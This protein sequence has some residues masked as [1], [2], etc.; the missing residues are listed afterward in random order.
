V[1]GGHFLHHHKEEGKGKETVSPFRVAS[2]REKMSVSGS[3]SRISRIV[4]K[5]E[6]RENLMR[7]G[8][9]RHEF[10]GKK[11]RE[12]REA[13][14]HAQHR[15]KKERFSDHLSPEGGRKSRHFRRQR[16]EK[17]RGR[18]FSLDPVIKK[19]LILYALVKRKKRREGE[20]LPLQLKKKEKKGGRGASELSAYCFSLGA[21]CEERGKKD[22]LI[23]FE[24]RPLWSKKGKRG[25]RGGR[26]LAF[27]TLA[28]KIN[29]LLYFM[30]PKRRRGDKVKFSVISPRLRVKEQ[31]GRGQM[32]NIICRE[33]EKSRI[34]V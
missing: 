2:N 31:E 11:K 17:N 15:A 12:G 20:V 28:M 4:K 3:C 25:K 24:R 8:R 1:A 5:K 34:G 13:N 29:A 7:G 19:N 21:G 10:K 6:G 22:R 9:A 14:R 32:G 26:E 23:F 27:A 18:Q 16:E 30:Q 33:R